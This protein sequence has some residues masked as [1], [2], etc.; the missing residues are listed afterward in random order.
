MNSLIDST[1]H[2]SK[3]G[4]ARAGAGRKPTL[5]DAQPYKVTLDAETAV[6]MKRL[7][8]GNLSAGVRIAA[9]AMATAAPGRGSAPPANATPSPEPSTFASTRD[10]A[11]TD[12][13]EAL[14]PGSV[15][16]SR[17]HGRH[18]SSLSDADMRSLKDDIARTGGNVIPVMVRRTVDYQGTEVIRGYDLVYGR[19]R[20]QA[21]LELGLPLQAVVREMSIAEAYVAMMVE[22]AAN[23]SMYE[24]GT[25]LKRALDEGLY[26]SRRRLVEACGLEHGLVAAALDV[27]ALPLEVLQA[28]APPTL[29]KA[30]ALRPLARALQRNPDE[31]LRRARALASGKRQAAAKVVAGLCS[32]VAG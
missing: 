30:T 17:Y 31:V 4:G 22:A 12:G 27:V 10:R 1:P 5:V 25:S 9:A 11:L 19:R 14:D 16:V 24:L 3:R 26:P 13:F 23:W 18:E 28:F 8:A 29:I 2:Q 6:H 32:E 21:C 20:L 7:G 15:Q